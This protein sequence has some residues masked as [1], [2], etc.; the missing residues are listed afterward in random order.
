[1]IKALLC[2]FAHRRAFVFNAVETQIKTIEV[3][4]TGISVT[5]K[6]NSNRNIPVKQN[7]VFVISI[8]FIIIVSS[9]CFKTI[10]DFH[11]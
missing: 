4:K 1:M 11:V 5:E 9:V 2:I 8:I 10:R 3:C 6:E 7:T